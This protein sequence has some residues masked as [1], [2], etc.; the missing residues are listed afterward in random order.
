[1]TI[2]LDFDDTISNSSDTFVEYAKKYNREN[3]INYRINI[4]TLDQHKAFGWSTRQQKEFSNKYLK[5]ILENVKPNKNAVEIINKLIDDGN[6]IIIITA[7]CD[8]EV[9]DME[10]LTKNWLSKYKIKYSELIVGSKS[11]EKICR[12]KN[13]DVFID[14]NINNCQEVYNELKI[15]TII[16]STRYNVSYNL[17]Q[18]IRISKWDEIYPIINRIKLGVSHLQLNYIDVDDK[19][20]FPNETDGMR[21]IHFYGGSKNYRAYLAPA[22]MSRADFMKLYPDY[23][24]EQN[25]PIYENNGIVVRADPKYPCPGFYIFALEETY[26]A[27]DLLDDMTFM[28]F[29]FILKKIKEGMRSRLNINY[30]HLLSNEKSDSYVNVHFWLVPV[31]GENSPDLLDFDVKKYLESFNPKEQIDKIISYNN[32]LK[33]YIKEIDLVTLDNA[34]TKQ[35]Q[36]FQSKR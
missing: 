17:P 11:K 16:F 26:R 25:I 15:P 6:K 18:I 34:L 31:D 7:R 4:D 21:Y 28:R 27:F 33:E 23:I 1:M 5:T 20:E 19:K 14:D 32:I 30:A 12:E 2:G 29:S 22:D 9:T 24:P 3:G 13:I 10:K 36:S 35:M 8:D